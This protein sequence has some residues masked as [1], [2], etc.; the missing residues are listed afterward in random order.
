MK[1]AFEVLRGFSRRRASA[2]R[3]ELCS[4][5]VGPDHPHV[6]ECAKGRILCACNPC[7]ILLA[8]RDGDRKLITIPRDARRLDS[9]VMDDAAWYA[10]RLPIDL[11]FFVRNS[12][13]GRIIAYY[14]SPAGSTES[15]LD[16]EAW[17]EIAGN[18]PM[19]EQMEP[20]V[21]ALLVDRTRG[22]RRYFIAPI[23]QCYR[24]S[25]VIRTQWRGFSGGDEVWREV[26]RFF[27]ALGPEYGARSHA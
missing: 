24:L 27:E 23:D 14:P 11:A 21:E 6:F 12:A 16:F 7:A 18:N 19:L 5:A 20:Y 2:E 3:C 9:F 13:E 17:D 22:H 8:H 1:S 4:L 25:G 10:L 26:D 15:R